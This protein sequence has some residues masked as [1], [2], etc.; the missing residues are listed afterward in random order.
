MTF[1]QLE[2]VVDGLIIASA[3]V[4]FYLQVVLVE[5]ESLLKTPEIKT[6]TVK[7]S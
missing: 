1:Y 4:F 3:N 7:N 6:K 5:A 2:R